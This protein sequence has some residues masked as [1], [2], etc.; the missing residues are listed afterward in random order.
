MHL[1]VNSLQNKIEE[2]KMLIEQFKA[3]VVFL[4]E[5]KIDGLYPSS[6]FAIRNC[7]DIYRSDDRVKGGRGLMAYFAS[8]LPLKRLKQPRVFKTIEVLIIQSA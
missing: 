1:N 8:V 2:V 7:I 5:T 3:Q 4:A 6:Q